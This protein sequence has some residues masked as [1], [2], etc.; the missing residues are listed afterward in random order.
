LHGSPAW[1]LGGGR[2]A[3]QHIGHTARWLDSSPVLERSTRSIDHAAP[4]QAPGLGDHHFDRGL[5]RGRLVGEHIPHATAEPLPCGTE[6]RG[7]APTGG[8]EPLEAP[9]ETCPGM[10]GRRQTAPAHT[11]EEPRPLRFHPADPGGAPQRG[12]PGPQPRESA[13]HGT[14]IPSLHEL[15]PHRLAPVHLGV[16]RKLR[17]SPVGHARLV[18]QATPPLLG[19]R[20]QR[21]LGG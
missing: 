17:W 2:L 7:K 5:A 14:L 15:F 6:D 9:E 20:P 12:R 16:G 4:R 3:H 19:P 13:P 21:R 18:R 8:I 10:G 11:T 1:H